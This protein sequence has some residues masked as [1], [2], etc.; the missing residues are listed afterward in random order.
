MDYARAELGR[1]TGG[2]LGM[3]WRIMRG[4]NQ[5]LSMPSAPHSA[6]SC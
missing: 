3:P 1:M 4:V 2:D 6:P 5:L